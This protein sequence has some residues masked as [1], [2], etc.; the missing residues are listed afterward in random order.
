MNDPYDNETRGC[1][2]EAAVSIP[3]RPIFSYR[4]H[5]LLWLAVTAITFF[6]SISFV[7][8]HHTFSLSNNLPAVD[9]GRQRRLEDSDSDVVDE[10][11]GMETNAA[12]KHATE[13]EKSSDLQRD[14]LYQKLSQ[15]TSLSLPL[16]PPYRIVEVGQKRTGSTF[17][18]QLLDAIAQIKSK[19][20]EHKVE[21]LGY[22]TKSTKISKEV[23]NYPESFVAKSHNINDL[24]L[25][26]A[27]REGKLVVFTSGMGL[28]D[29][30]YDVGLY[31]QRRS[32]LESCSMCEIDKYQHIFR[33]T[34]EE[35]SIIKDYMSAYEKI[36]QC[37][38]MQMSHAERARLN[39]CDMTLVRQWSG[40]PHCELI[41]KQAEEQKLASFNDVIEH[42][43]N[44]P[45]DNWSQ[46]GDCAKFDARISRGETRT[47]G[48]K[49][50]C[51]Y[52]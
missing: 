10:S 16:E 29:K 5:K 37:C 35:L 8:L 44:S 30:M 23:D 41:D 6:F 13:D 18:F 21:F 36:R 14:A 4:A 3:P 17:Q 15:K 51:P 46:V 28:S 20:T 52:P 12:F 11:K 22:V 40:Y 2:S 27:Q 43:A 49:Y 9:E 48:H 1:N 33:L 42:R 45:K 32:D 26:Q 39:G 31:N 50:K 34:D 25:A 38:G 47:G 24:D 7:W 19:G